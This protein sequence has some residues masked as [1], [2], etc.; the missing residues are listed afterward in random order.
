MSSLIVSTLVLEKA[1]PSTV[2]HIYAQIF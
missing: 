1:V 2:S